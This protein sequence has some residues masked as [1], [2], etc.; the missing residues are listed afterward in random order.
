MCMEIN[1]H[2]HDMTAMLK[3]LLQKVQQLLLSTKTNAIF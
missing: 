2:T 1:F 3:K